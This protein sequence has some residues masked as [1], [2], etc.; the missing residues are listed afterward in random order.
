MRDDKIPSEDAI[1]L[2]D[3]DQKLKELMLYIADRCQDDAFFGATKLN[4]VLFWS[5]MLY[6]AAHGETITGAEYQRLQFGPAPRRM[7]PAIRDLEAEKRGAIRER[8][9]MK[10]TQ[11][12]L[13][14]LADANLQPFSAEQIAHVNQIMHAL[15]RQGA[16]QLS[17]R[18][19]DDATWLF[20]F[21][22]ETINPNAIFISNQPIT[23][24]EM[25]PGLAEAKAQG[26]L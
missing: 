3:P 24:S 10:G 25:E 26:L 12:R 9:T 13:V 11:K 8:Q 2:I 20:A 18:T 17:N 6:Y 15:E 4:K 16:D 14:P 19:H 7:L 5:D 22:G 23:R 1:Y 21:D